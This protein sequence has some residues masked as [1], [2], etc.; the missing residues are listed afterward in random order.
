MQGVVR[1]YVVRQGLLEGI[2]LL[3]EFIDSPVMTKRKQLLNLYYICEN[4]KS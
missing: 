1:E 3:G 4:A 2:I